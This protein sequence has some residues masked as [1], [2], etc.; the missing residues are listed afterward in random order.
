[1]NNEVLRMMLLLGQ[2]GF[3]LLL[4]F[5]LLGRVKQWRQQS[6]GPEAKEQAQRQMWISSLLVLATTAILWTLPTRLA[7]DVA[8]HP[9]PPEQQDMS[10]SPAEFAPLATPTA[11]PFEQNRQENEQAKQRFEQL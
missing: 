10:N 1:V 5:F 2:L 7:Q 9:P 3:S 8:N 6:G 4:L 11:D